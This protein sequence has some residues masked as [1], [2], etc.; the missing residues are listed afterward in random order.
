MPDAS[1]VAAEVVCPLLHEYEYGPPAP[2]LADAVALP[3]LFPK[4]L[5]LVE[6]EAVLTNVLLMVIVAKSETVIGPP[7]AAFTT[8]AV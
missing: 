2:R 3:V 7:H 4:Q 6:T 5:T 1:P 8:V